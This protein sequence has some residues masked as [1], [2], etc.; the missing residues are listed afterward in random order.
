MLYRDTYVTTPDASLF[1]SRPNNATSMHVLCVAEKP[2]IAKS[3]SQILSSGQFTTV[4]QLSDCIIYPFTY[5]S[6]RS[7]RN[8]F[9]K[10]YDFTYPRTN[11]TF[12]V[13]SVSGHLMSS[14][15]GSAYRSWSSCDPVILFDVPVETKVAEDK[16]SIE[17]NLLSEARG[18]QTLM[19]WTDC[20]REGE[21][22]G[23]EIAN[24]CKKANRNLQI[25]RARFSAI[26]AQ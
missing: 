12:T 2:S 26:I 9:I 4:C 19:I 3:V 1:V 15:F 14:D 22:I 23:M 17:Q 7:T 6:Q 16:K 21:N 8:K 24:V 18:C 11:D 10:N 20:D 13:T 5:C 25:K